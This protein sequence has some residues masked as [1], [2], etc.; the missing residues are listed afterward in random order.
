MRLKIVDVL[1]KAIK[2]L[3]LSKQ[4]PTDSTKLNR[5]ELGFLPAALEI[6]E[7]PPSPIGRA[8]VWLLILLFTITITWAWIGQVDEVAIASGKVIPSGY[9]KII[10]AEDKG[11]VKRIHVKD[12]SK[13]QPSEVLIEL[14]TTI[15]GADLARLVK[16]QAYYQL[17]IKRLAAEQTGQPFIPEQDSN[18]NLQDMQYQLQLFRSRMDEYQAKIV[19]AQ[20]GINQSRAAIDIAQSTQQKLAMQLEIAADKESKMRELVEQGAVSQFQYQDYKERR[21]TLHQDHAAQTTEIIK[22]NYA[23]LQSME[24]LNNIIS[25]RDRD[26]MTKLVDNRRQLQSVEEELK[27]A[28]EK[29]RLSTII[30]PIAGTVQQLAIHT[31]GGVV[32]PAQI[33]MLIVPEGAKMEIEAWV[34]NKDIGFVYE[35]QN[36]EIKVE[37]FNFQKYGTLDAR[38]LEISSD[39]VEDKEKG[40]VYRAILQTELD[41]FALANERKAYLAPGM[42]VTAEIK[43]RQKKIIEYFMDPFIKYRSEGLRER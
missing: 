7:T 10:Q 19:T 43:T 30:A 32:T 15:T 36:A 3:K 41:Y 33:L 39:A 38:L 20:Q 23:L 26:I 37:T 29:Y 5:S 12:G 18:V 2:G 6:V 42:A 27:K 28:R 8:L 1:A 9:T 4:S 14:D 24:S 22:V 13:V 17:E 25:E 11:V 40:L 16:E 34:A 21:I 35:G 31:V